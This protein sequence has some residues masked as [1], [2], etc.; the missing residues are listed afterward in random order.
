MLEA[1]IMVEDVSLK[2]ARG[3]ELLAALGPVAGTLRTLEIS[4]SMVLPSLQV[5]AVDLVARVHDAARRGWTATATSTESVPQWSF[6]C[7]LVHTS[8]LR[9]SCTAAGLGRGSPGGADRAHEPRLQ[10]Q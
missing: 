9:L 3:G 2:N 4:S 6:F 8:L 10:R 7:E 1:A 5:R